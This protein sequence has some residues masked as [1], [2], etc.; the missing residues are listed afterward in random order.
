MAPGGFITSA[1]GDGQ[2]Y[3]TQGTS[4]ASP[5]VAGGIALMQQI[6][7]EQLNRKLSVEEVENIINKNS[8]SIYDGDNENI[9]YDEVNVI[10]SNQYYNFIDLNAYAEAISELKDPSFYYVNLENETKRNIDFGV[11]SNL[12]NNFSSSSENIFIHEAF[13]QTFA[14]AGDD[15]IYGSSGPDVIQGGDGN[16]EIFSSDGNDTLEGGLGNDYIDVGRRRYYNSIRV[17]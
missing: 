14:G 4:M 10:P 1:S 15:S 2:Y 9:Y 3:V 16:D 17:F 12:V 13:A 7:E 11:T 8:L 5:Y 6:A